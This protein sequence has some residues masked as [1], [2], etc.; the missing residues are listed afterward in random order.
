MSLT[1]FLVRGQSAKQ[2]GATRGEQWP[3]LA[4]RRFILYDVFLHELGHLQ[5][6][7]ED[8]ASV[9]RKFSMETKAQ[10]FA[11]QWC[12]RLW[13]KPFDHF[14]PVHNP[15]TAEELA[16]KE[17]ETTELLRRIQLR[18]TTPNYSSIWQRFIISAG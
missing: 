15:P 18:R 6:V 1:R 10:A 16:D 12:K 7:D 2:F 8:A 9:R 5:V 4:I 3:A 11:M 13:S 14:D 17:P